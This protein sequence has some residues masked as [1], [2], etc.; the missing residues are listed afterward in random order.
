MSLSVS[1]VLE[2]K[3][4]LLAQLD[5]RKA[6]AATLAEEIAAIGDEHN[7]VS[8]PSGTRITQSSLMWMP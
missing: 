5:K 2:Q 8:L 1:Q 3:N 4:S 7:R 6:E